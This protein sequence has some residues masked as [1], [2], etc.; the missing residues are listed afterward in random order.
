MFLS[1]IGQQIDNICFAMF[2]MRERLDVYMEHDASDII[3]GVWEWQQL[4]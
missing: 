2:L 3:A 1:V 4:S